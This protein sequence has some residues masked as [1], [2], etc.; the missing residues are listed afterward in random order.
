M[1]SMRAREAPQIRSFWES[2]QL[3]PFHEVWPLARRFKSN[4]NQMFFFRV[5]FNTCNVSQT[6]LQMPVDMKTD[7]DP[8]ETGN[9]FSGARWASAEKGGRNLSFYS[10]GSN[11]VT[12]RL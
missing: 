8:P 3:P 6:G 11:V 1:I 5:F 7:P 10:V 2:L 12:Q 9:R 4:Q